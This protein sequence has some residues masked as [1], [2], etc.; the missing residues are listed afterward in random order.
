MK[1]CRIIAA[2]EK[3]ILMSFWS[4]EKTPLDTA[5]W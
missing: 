2:M 4:C 5:S 3:E 1:I